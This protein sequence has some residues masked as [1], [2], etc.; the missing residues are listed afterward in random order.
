MDVQK[1]SFP[2]QKLARAK[3]TDEWGHESIDAIIAREGSGFVGGTDRKGTMLTAYGLYNSEYDENDLKYVTNPFKVEDGFPAK[4]QNFN[5]I[6]PKIDLLIGEESKRPFNVKV[7]QTNYDAVTKVQEE[8]KTLLM[9]Y[10][11]SYIG[12]GQPD[13]NGQVATPPEIEKYMKYNYKTISEETAFHTLNYLKERLNVPNEFLKGWKDALIASE[14]IYYVGVVNGEPSMERVNPVYC[15]YDKDPDL[16]YIEDGD[17]FL[18]RMEM[19]PASIYDRFFD[20]LDESDLDKILAYS[21]GRTTF[22]QGTGDY[23]NNRSVMYKEK[24]SNKIFGDQ[25]NGDND[26]NLLT[27]Y[28]SVWRSYT[29][30]GFLKVTNPETGEV[31]ETMV[32]ETYKVGPGEEINWEWLPEIWEG[33]RAGED[34][35]FGIGPVEYQHVSIDSPSNRKL[36]YCGTIY[37]NINSRAKSL[38]TIMKPLQYMYIILWYRLELALARDKGKV[39][40]MDITQ[41]PKGL[42]ISVE[43]WMHYVSA[44]GV[45]FVNPYDEGW[46]IPGREGGKPAAYNQMTSMDLSMANAISEY[47]NLMAKIEDMIGEISGVSKQRQ[48]AITSNELVGNVE[49]AVIQSSHITEPLFWVHNQVKKNALTMLLDTAKSVW[50]DSDKQRKK[51]HYLM[52]DSIRVFMDITDDFIYSDHDVFLS[53]S[54]KEETDIQSLRSMLQPAMSSGATLL[55][56]AEIITGE[57]MS[58]IKKRLQDIDQKKAEMVAAQQQAQQQQQQL[59]NQ[60]RT[61]ELRIKEE[62]SIR[63]AETSLQVAILGANS[64]ANAGTN[65]DEEGNDL[66]FEKLMLQQEKVQEDIRLKDEQVKETIRKN[67]RAE[68]QK[69]IELQ[70]KKKQ[71]NKPVS[72]TQ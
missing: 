20:L 38:V 64:A 51:L 18:R 57:N 19:S 61:E 49:R 68:E 40:T 42:G 56:A 27:V 62:D 14:E 9:Q 32:D 4:M 6:R 66:E 13:Q 63:K 55:E 22:G 26:G 16:E 5:I 17:W 41:I 36:P 58:M 65:V 30:T 60:L 46:D 3:K 11:Q 2:V 44:L 37:S 71:A 54:T 53:D 24:F 34:T 8:K 1:S 29:K 72:K 33:Y 25:N 59:E 28:H 10:I 35:Y 39:L 47:I 69:D 23:V 31:I 48:G 50:G 21:D 45:N 52:N 7:I 67:K 12:P 70:I 43:Q 15:D